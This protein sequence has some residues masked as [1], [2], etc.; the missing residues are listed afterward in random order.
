MQ[1]LAC[2]HCGSLKYCKN[3][4]SR[5]GIQVFKCKTC[6]KTFLE[7]YKV[8]LTDYQME[9]AIRARVEGNSYRAIAR[10]LGDVCSWFAIYTFLKKLPTFTE[11]IT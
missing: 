7:E 9:I 11:N 1:K 8:T 10:L 2:N 4:H 6:A 5:K 3:G